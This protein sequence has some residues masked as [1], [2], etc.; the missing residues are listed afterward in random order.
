MHTDEYPC[1]CPACDSYSLMEDEY[2][3][4]CIHHGCR[5][6]NPNC[7]DAKRSH[8]WCDYCQSKT[9][10]VPAHPDAEENRICGSCHPSGELP[11]SEEW[12]ETPEEKT[13]SCPRCDAEYGLRTTASCTEC[14]FIPEE[15]QV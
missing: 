15:N 1:P 8:K 12:W 7:P 6:N 4:K 13:V 3:T 14:G 2:C 5:G 11:D 9:E 10:T